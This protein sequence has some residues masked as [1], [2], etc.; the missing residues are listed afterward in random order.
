M[1]NLLIAL[2]L[3]PVFLFGQKLI[4][5]NK[6]DGL[7][8]EIIIYRDGVQMKHPITIYPDQHAEIEVCFLCRYRVVCNSMGWPDIQEFL[9]IDGGNKTITYYYEK[10][11]A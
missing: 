1:K 5:W 4:L 7:K 8:L 10:P 6:T 11:K 2:F 3:F 9:Q